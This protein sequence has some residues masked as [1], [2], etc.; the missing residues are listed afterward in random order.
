MEPTKVGVIGAGMAGPALA[1]FLKAKG[2]SP[3]VYER[4][5]KPSEAGLGI[6][7]QQGGHQVLAKIPGLLEHLHGWPR[8]EWH[9]YSVVEED[10]G[11]LGTSDSEGKVRERKG[12]GTIC[13]RRPILQQRLVEFAEKAGVPFKWGH[14]LESLQQDDERVTVSFANGA[15]ETFSFVVGCDGL[16][17]NT[18]A[19]LFGEH[20]AT[21]VGLCMWGGV[22]PAPDYLR[23][24]SVAL[25]VYGNGASMIV[26]PMDE[27][28]VMWATTQSEPE[29]KET[30]R[31]VD[32]TVA[33]EFK[34]SSPYSK[35]GFGVGELVRDSTSITKVF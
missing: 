9:F 27:T 24:K 28:T 35:W 23:G 1:L 25:D 17:S 33:E 14:K 31:T 30:W 18:R 3:I 8:D 2:Y 12:L 29:S 11:L 32:E 34:K 13:M 6:G 19:C 4:N 22:S 20:P 15:R 26:I 21:Y 16:H 5:N 10:E 7:V